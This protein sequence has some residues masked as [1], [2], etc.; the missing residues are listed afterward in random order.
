M[1]IRIGFLTVGSTVTGTEDADEIYGNARGSVNVATGSDRIFGLG[2]DDRIV[3]DT[4]SYEDGNFNFFTGDIGP[5]GKG[6]NDLIQGGDG[7]D[8]I[9][10]DTDSDLLGIGGNDII[11]QDAGRGTLVGDARV[12]SS[13]TRCGN[14]QL[15]GDGFLY[16]DGNFGS[17]AVFGNDLLVASGSSGNGSELWGDTDDTV[18]VATV[19][20]RD[21]L[22]GGTFGD[23]LVGDVQELDDASRGGNDQLWGNGGDDSLYGDAEGGLFESSRGGNDVLRGGNGADLIYGDGERISEF[24]HGGNDR[25]LGGAGDDQLWGDGE[26]LESAQGGKDR[27]VFA[28]SFGDDSI[29][30]FRTT[31]GDQIIFQ[32][33]TR[34]EVTQ[35]I[36]TVTDPNDS[37][38]ITTLGGESVTLVGFTGPLNPGVDIVFA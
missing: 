8:D 37:L 20:G 26:L 19:C 5:A 28:G 15:F 32:G 16:G 29:L 9:Y 12:V 4:G 11:Y 34:S 6:G 21:T 10:G 31:D 7:D 25:L 2:G 38:Q 14:D 35:T 1:A 23:L 30:D 36:V 27:F 22:R 3:G 33:L 24:A 18:F 17:G 13:T